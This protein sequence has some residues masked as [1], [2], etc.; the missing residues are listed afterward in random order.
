MQV[1]KVYR[2]DQIVVAQVWLADNIL[3]RARGLLG[4]PML[5]ESQGL[6]IQPCNSI[7]TFGMRYSLDVVFMDS[8]G[9]VLKFYQSLPSFRLA[10]TFGASAVLELA[11]GEVERIGLSVG[12]KLQWRVVSD[13]A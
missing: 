12:D 11:P 13:D 9:K 7:H 2:H 3:S 4:R 1:G 10:A 8:E 6:L 5:Q